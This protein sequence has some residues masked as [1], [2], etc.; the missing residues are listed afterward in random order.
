MMRKMIIN[1][2]DFGMSEAVNFGVIKGYSDGIVS[3]TTLM[4]NMPAAEHAIT[5]AKT[6]PD[7]FIGQHTNFVLGKPCSKP[8][9]IP[10]LVDADGFF[11]GSKDYKTG[12]R[13]FVYEDVKIEAIAQMERFKELTGHYPQHIEGHSAS[14]QA[15]GR[16]FYE[17]AKQYKIH[18]SKFS[19]YT[20][21]SLEDYTTTVPVSLGIR[22]VSER[23]I[24]VEDFLEDRFKLMQVSDEKVVELHLHPGYID[25]FVLEH[26]TLTIP[27]C[28]DLATLCDSRVKEW[29]EGNNISLISFGDLKKITKKGSC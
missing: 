29:I 3:S 14:D 10:S 13:K 17:I 23:C 22:D 25:Q 4:V 26:S 24:L 1:A 11:L 9:E 20:Q 12:M 21:H 2:D 28:R 15:V 27:R 19:G 8:K 18:A 5:L 6:V 16:A 7:L